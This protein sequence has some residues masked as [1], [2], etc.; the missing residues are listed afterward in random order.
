VKV[1]DLDGSLKRM[2]GD[3]DLFRGL[4]EYFF[5]DAPPLVDRIQTALERGDAEQVERAAHSVKGL[6]ANFGADFVVKAAA[7][8]EELGKRAALENSASA[9]GELRA[10]LATLLEQLQEYRRPLTDKEASA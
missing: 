1:L 5:L 9:L 7:R 3:H 4:A 2:G 6:A 10:Q 8:L